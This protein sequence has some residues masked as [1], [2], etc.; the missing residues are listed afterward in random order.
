MVVGSH[1]SPAQV[2][3]RDRHYVQDANEVGEIGKVGRYAGMPIPY[4]SCALALVQQP[5]SWLELARLLSALESDIVEIRR[6]GGNDITMYCNIFYE[7]QCNFEF[8]REELSSICNMEID[9]A[10]SC[11]RGDWT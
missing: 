5:G 3:W 6:F 8:S 2:G 9:L 10:I 4:G 7:E 1:F 11:F